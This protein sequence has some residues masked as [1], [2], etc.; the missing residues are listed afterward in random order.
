MFLLLLLLEV[1]VGWVGGGGMMGFLCASW[2]V[3]EDRYCTKGKSFCLSNPFSRWSDKKILILTIVIFC[4]MFF[5][6]IASFSGAFGRKFCFG[7]IPFLSQMAL[8]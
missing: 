2:C 6:Q 1:G 5:G 7:F 3:V 4:I 8:N